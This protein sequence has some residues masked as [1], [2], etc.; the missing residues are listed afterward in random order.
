MYLMASSKGM[1]MLDSL[2]ESMSL[3]A[4]LGFLSISKLRERV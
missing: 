3:F 2:N 1:V 4:S